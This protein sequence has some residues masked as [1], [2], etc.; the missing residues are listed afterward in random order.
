MSL[1]ACKTKKVAS[2]QKTEKTQVNQQEEG[3][4]ETDYQ[5]INGEECFGEENIPTFQAFNEGEFFRGL[6]GLPMV[7][8]AFTTDD[9]LLEE[10]LTK[11]RDGGTH[12]LV[13]PV[14][15]NNSTMCR[16]F[17]LTESSTL[18]PELQKKYPQ[19]YSLKGNE[20]GLES[21]TARIAY[22][23]DK[24]LNA[25]IN[26][27]KSIVIIERRLINSKLFYLVYDKKESGRSA[28]EF[29]NFK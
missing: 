11:Y 23:P 28:E 12:S 7:F 8:S 19:L 6:S 20:L 16:I 4:V 27:D 25:Y 2:T 21:H 10:Y 14:V 3:V 24:G 15:S 26:I 1:G 13:L 18:S 5:F 17:K 29:E 22:D 9:A